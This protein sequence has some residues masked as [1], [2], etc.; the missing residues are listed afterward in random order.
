[1]SKV[2]IKEITSRY[3]TSPLEFDYKYFTQFSID[4]SKCVPPRLICEY[5]YDSA[6]S[7][8]NICS[9][10]FINTIKGTSIEGQHLTGKKLTIIGKVYLNIIFRE[11]TDRKNIYLIDEIIPFSTFIIVPE[12]ICKNEDISILYNVE[13]IEVVPIS[14]KKILISVMLLLKYDDIG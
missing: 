10:K 2:K 11:K 8:I 9:A 7:H 14:E 13:D 1:M 12:D 5:F 4:S 6:C 3:I